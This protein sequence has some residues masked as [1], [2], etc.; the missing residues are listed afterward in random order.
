MLAEMTAVQSSYDMYVELL[1]DKKASDRE[2]CY[3]MKTF[4]REAERIFNKD[5][6]TCLTATQA[7]KYAAWLKETRSEYNHLKKDDFK[8]FHCDRYNN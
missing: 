6:S 2:T 5:Y 3:Y 1:G 7:E 8:A 4:L